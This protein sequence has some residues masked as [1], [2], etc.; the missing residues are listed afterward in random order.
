[1]R[2]IFAR[3]GALVT[4]TATVSALAIAGQIATATATVA[5]AIAIEIRTSLLDCRMVFPAFP[6]CQPSDLNLNTHGAGMQR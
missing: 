6:G 2:V 1:M 4:S 3:R 5:A